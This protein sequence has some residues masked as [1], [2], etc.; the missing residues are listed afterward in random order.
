MRL[1]IVPISFADPKQG[2]VDGI[3]PKRSLR[4]SVPYLVADLLGGGFPP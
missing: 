1:Y 3:V 4:G 2:G